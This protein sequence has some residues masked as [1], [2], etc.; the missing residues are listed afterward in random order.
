MMQW[1]ALFVRI[2]NIAAGESKNVEFKEGLPE[3]SS[4]IFKNPEG[5]NHVVT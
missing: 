3:K 5:Y 1:L 4:K 2:Y